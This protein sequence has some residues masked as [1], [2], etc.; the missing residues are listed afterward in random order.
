M[1]GDPFHAVFI[2]APRIER[3]G[4]DVEVLATIDG[5]PIAVRQANAI[6]TSF[7]PE[8]TDD[9]RIHRWFVNEFEIDY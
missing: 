8:L 3:I 7:H 1:I 4:V 2:R 6:A 9:T 5:E